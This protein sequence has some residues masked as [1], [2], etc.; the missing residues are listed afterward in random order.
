MDTHF[1]TSFLA[2]LLAARVTT[3]GL[4]VMRRFEELARANTTYFSCFAAGVLISVSFLHIIPE[5]FEMAK[6]APV[7]LLSGYVAMHLLNRILIA[8]VC[9]KPGTAD[10]PMG[11]LPLLGLPPYSKSF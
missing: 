10:F 2:S 4:L 5:A 9:D 11:L 6:A 7:W 1:W 3:V 8:F